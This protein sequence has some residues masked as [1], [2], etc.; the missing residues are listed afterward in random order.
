MTDMKKILYT[1]LALVLFAACNTK[2]ITYTGPMYIAFADTLSVCPVVAS[3]EPFDVYIAA[4]QPS[5]RDR[6]FSV[7]VLN[8]KSN[9]IYG[10]HFEIENQTVTIPA[11]ELAT[12]VRIIGNYDNI[13]ASD[14][15]SVVL[16]L[17]S[18][19]EYEWDLYGQTTRV[20]LK[21]A[22][23]FDINNFTGWV[24]VT[25][26]FWLQYSS[27]LHFERVV[28]CE[29]I[30]G[31]PNSFIIRDFLMDGYDVK[32]KVDPTDLLNPVIEMDGEQIVGDTRIPFQ[33]V[34][35]DGRIRGFDEP[36][37]EPYFDICNKYA[38]TFMLMY[39]KN[40][41]T[42]GAFVNIIEWI[43]DEEANEL[44]SEL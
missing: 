11:G 17:L 31:K 37:I 23:A 21:K 36:S 39:V 34:Y 6:T 2:H 32:F 12:S 24:K 15:L 41:G 38:E 33:M 3:G 30:E 7:E 26:S 27:S 20:E 5:D 43:T 22:C 35:G 1:L 28:K 19:D 14:S 16:S 4:T 8:K 9:A 44:L 13:A 40:V 42:I 10:H 18:V 25:S 29:P